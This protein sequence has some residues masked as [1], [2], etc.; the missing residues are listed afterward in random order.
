MPRRNGDA[1]MIRR[2]RL[3]SGLVMLAY[4]AMHLLNHALGLVSLDAM[5]W[6][7]DTLVLPVWAPLPAQTL[8]YG[9]FLAHYALALWALW[10]RRTLRLRAAEYAQIVLGF[11]IPILLVK[12][13]VGVRLSH[14]FGADLGSYAYVLRVYFVDSP[15][16]GY[17]QMA[18][19][20]VAWA[21]AMLGLH[22]WLR[23][24][25]W[26][27]RWMQPALVLAVLVPV[28][29][30]LGMIE[31][32]RKV[33]EIAADPAAA[34]QLASGVRFPA[35]ADVATLKA[36]ESGLTWFFVAAVA[37]VL[38]ARLGRFGWQR[39]RGSVRVS[40][41]DGRVIDVLPG[42]SVLEASRLLRFPHASICGG[43]GRCSTCRI[44][45]RAARPGLAPPGDEEGRVLSRIR[46]TGNVRLACQ[47]RPAVD[48]EVTPLLPAVAQARDA[49]RQVDVAQ[50]SER[51]VAVMFV[52]IRGFTALAEGRLPYDV[53]F[54]LN[55][56]FAAMGRAVEHAGGRVD[57]FIGDGVMA[58][59]GLGGSVD[60]ACRDALA[61]ARAMSLRLGELNQ[62]LAAEL[63]EPLRI[64][65]GIHVG[66]V[67]VGEMG[68]GSATTITAIGDAVN[69]ASRLEG[70][71]KEYAAELVVSAEIIARAG[72]DLP[73]Q[74]R[75]AIAIRGRQ[76]RL[77]VAVFASAQDLPDTTAGA[78]AAAVATA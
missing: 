74:R 32:G 7:L 15:W 64:G 76:E 37:A 17:Q 43:R 5:G 48:V 3:A 14:A 24:R 44:R 11:L 47:L 62:S 69:T 57:K 42:T 30:L 4:V 49:D 29:S 18:V 20:V 71:T 56:Y 19:L 38:A 75:E 21:H 26:Y 34:R 13:V 22:F 23:L 2:I 77:A 41:P 12:H 68:Y 78:P 54:I 53:V 73:H 16:V 25:P 27:E 60:T 33:A 50:G 61:A 8:L 63:S 45:V 6:A 28:L 67:I 9:A 70:L 35:R 46:A 72:L 36:I 59:F 40:Y 66:P 10:Q 55:R 52:D 1:A 51:E 58:L 31:A 65:I 39:R